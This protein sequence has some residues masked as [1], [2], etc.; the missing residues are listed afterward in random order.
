MEKISI[1]TMQNVAIEQSPASVGDRIVATLVDVG[2]AMAY[3]FLAFILFAISESLV[4]IIILAIPLFLYHLLCELFM[5]GQSWGKKVVNIK[6]VMLDG[7]E[8]GFIAYFLR[9]IFRIIDIGLFSGGVALLTVIINGKGQR[10]GDIAAKT[11][12]IKLKEKSLSDT[13]YSRLPD[14]YEVVFQEV[15]KL[16]DQDIMTA[17]EVLGF[18]K[19]SGRSMDSLHMA[20][21]A[22]NAL[23]AKMSIESHFPG[24]RFLF[25]VVRD[26][27]FIHSRG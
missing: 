25:T 20:T 9:W 7:T 27:N 13:I 18:V 8:P 26:Y 12:V 1:N 3:Y 21:K 10:L 11:T 4:L 6:V 23:A 15:R 2:I 14:N 16:S 19:S 24:E 22:K 17:K 5:N